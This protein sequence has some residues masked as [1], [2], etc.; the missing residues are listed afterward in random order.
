MVSVISSNGRKGTNPLKHMTQETSIV[1]PKIING[2]VSNKDV[3]LSESW[4][5]H[6]Q[7]DKTCA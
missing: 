1:P 7:P 6:L 5:T 4:Q 2:L 3:F